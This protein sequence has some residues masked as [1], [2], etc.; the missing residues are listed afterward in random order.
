M[1]RIFC[2]TAAVWL[3]VVLV[4]GLVSPSLSVRAAGATDTSVR[5]NLL[6]GTILPPAPDTS[7]YGS[8][9]LAGLGAVLSGVGDVNGDGYED[10]VVG[11]PYFR[12]PNGSH[13]GR[14]YLFL[15]S[16]SGL[17]PIPAWTV[18]GSYPACGNYYCNMGSE[19]GAAGDVN[20]DGYADVIVTT[21]RWSNSQTDEGRVLVYYGSTAGLGATPNWTAEGN[22]VR[23]YFGHM[24]G[25]AGDVNGDGYDDIIV[26]AGASYGV[27]FNKA[28]VYL[29]SPTGLSCGAGCPVDA[30][31][32]AAWTFTIPQAT[33]NVGGG[34]GTAGDLNGDGYSDVLVGAPLYDDGAKVDAGMV[35]AFLGSSAGPSSMP[36]WSAVGDQA[37]AQLGYGLGT[38]GDVNGDGYADFLVSA[39][40]YDN[41][42][43]DEGRVYL[44]LGSATGPGASAAWIG[45]PDKAYTA[46]GSAVH[47][48]GDLNGDGFDDVVIGGPEWD[49]DSLSNAGK[50]WG[51]LGSTAGLAGAAAWTAYSGQANATLGVAVGASDV[52]GDG[53]PDLLAGAHQYDQTYNDGGAVFVYHGTNHPPVAEANGP[54]T[55]P[56]GSSV[57]LDGTASY[58]P[59]P[60]DTL[61]YAWDLD[62]DGVYE[63][64]GATPSF[65][66]IDGPA[67][68]PVALQVC[69]QQAA[70]DSDTA[71]VEVTNVA[72]T[73]DAGGDVTVY[74]NE[75]V[76][77]AGA[78]TD[79][80]AALDEPYAWTWDLDGD[81]VA[82][83]SG[84]G[85]YG[86]TASATASFATEGIYDLTFTVTDADGDSGQD[87]VRVTV[88][89]SAPDCSATAA[90]PALLWPPNNK[91]V[92]VSIG[93]VADADGD[94]LTLAVT[95]IWQ[96]EPVGKGNSAPDG[97]GVGTATAELRTEKLGSGD[98]RVYHVF[99]TASDGHG[100]ACTGEVRVSVPHDQARPAVDGG[101]LHDSTVP[102]P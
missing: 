49:G 31:A 1:K 69:D 86:A 40:R 90:S 73:P 7:I 28:F 41:G 53:T 21:G 34:V 35:W 79:P 4:F 27:G 43:T 13:D 87:S 66:G 101:P 65:T 60:G 94:P 68:H 62:G 29:G 9:N 91:F 77:L 23:G 93:G 19:V 78:W 84:S 44:Y 15:G 51:Y 59:D 74:R 97:K 20:G 95:S 54:Y 25:T 5:P 76:S 72:P 55:V 33:A 16:A 50:V 3:A 82:D 32:A 24:P 71:T 63:T 8:A 64:A 96:D 6:P 39:P 30:T 10:V 98:G 14:A 48:L 36:T 102:T 17:N 26:G 88:L 61:T 57:T 18:S 46:Y 100:G 58:D 81:G 42:Q 99:F 75:P 52:N 92:R 45:E 38:A 12:G 83:A 89:N 85:A 11:A 67:S 56:E 2:S 37:G 80:A 70:C 47:T 22:R